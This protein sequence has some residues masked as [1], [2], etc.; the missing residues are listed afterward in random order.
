MPVRPGLGGS[1]TPQVSEF[2]P[3]HKWLGIPKR[4]QPPTYY[5][6]LGIDR[7]ELDADVIQAAADRQMAHVR[8]YQTGVNSAASQTVLNELATCPALPLESP[9]ARRKV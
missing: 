6:L 5:R 8:T 9:P 7:F 3:Y 2:D 1:E 4:E